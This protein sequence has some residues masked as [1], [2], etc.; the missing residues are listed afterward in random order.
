MYV[1]VSRCESLKTFSNF[2]FTKL[3]S[4]SDCLQLRAARPG[5][6]AFPLVH[7]ERRDAQQASEVRGREAKRGTPATPGAFGSKVVKVD[8][9][10][11]ACLGISD[12]RNRR[13]VRA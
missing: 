13:S 1:G 7:A 5:L 2:A 11:L 10:D 3:S 8:R 12:S 4:R 6:A 9:V